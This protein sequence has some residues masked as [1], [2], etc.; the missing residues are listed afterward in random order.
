MEIPDGWKLVPIEPT[1]E[2]T[3]AA[4]M[5]WYIKAAE[6]RRRVRIYRAMV[7]VAPQ[8]PDE[9]T[10]QEQVVVSGQTSL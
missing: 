3:E 2:M 7:A 1:P 6:A 10:E 5:G 8:T 4:G 9:L